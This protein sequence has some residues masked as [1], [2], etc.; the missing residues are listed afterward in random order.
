MKTI[1]P[2]LLM[3]VLAEALETMAFI[4]IEPAFDQ[5][6]C[7]NP[8]QVLLNFSGSVSGQLSLCA[9]PA[10]GMAIAA[11]LAA[12]EPEAVSAEQAADALRELAN[13]TAGLLLRQVCT[14]E[15]MPQLRIPVV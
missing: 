5:T 13:V 1:E 7:T 15:E 3:T 9:P 4:S 8:L 2:D 10:L 14:A 6:A 12:V 11:N